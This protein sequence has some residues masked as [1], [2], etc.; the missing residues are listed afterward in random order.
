VEKNKDTEKLSAKESL[1]IAIWSVKI[2]FQIDKTRSILYIVF[3]IL[4]NLQSIVN[5]ILVAK[6][7]DQLIHLLQTSEAELIDMVPIL[8][9]L[10]AYNVLAGVLGFFNNYTRSVL[11]ISVD[12][13][14]EQIFYKKLQA[15][16]IKT[17]EDPEINNK[18]TRA[19]GQISGVEFYFRQLISVASSMVSI[20]VNGAIILKFSPILIPI[21]V[22]TSIP[23]R[24]VDKKYRSLVWKLI[25]DTTEKQRAANSTAGNLKSPIT[26]PEIIINKATGYLD[27]KYTEYQNWYAGKNRALYKKWFIGIYSWELLSD[28]GMFSGYLIIFSNALKKLITIGDVYFQTQILQKLSSEINSAITLTNN[29]FDYSIR[30]KEVY[31]LFNLPDENVSGAIKLAKLDKGPEIEF[32]DLTFQYP[33]TIKKVINK[34]NL[35]IKSGEKIAIVGANGAGKTTLMKILC[36]VYEPTGGVILVNG[37]PLRDIENSTWYDNVGVLFQEYNTHGQLTVKENI[38]IGN[39]N[40]KFDSKKMLEAAQNADAL[41]FIQEYP[42]KFDQVLSQQYKN[43]IRPSTGQWQKIAIARFFYRNAPLVIFDEPTASIDSVSEYHIF[44]KIYRFFKRK[45]VIIISHRFSTVRNADRIVVIDKGTIVEEG[46]H[47]ELMKL[48]GKYNK[49]FSLQAE[50]YK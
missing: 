47:E 7:F 31:T 10:L 14:I 13:K 49:S 40:V 17:L 3:S 24:L 27:K 23:S 16:G 28:V 48:K 32:K 12:Q 45:T 46:T 29:L 50:G 8:G 33:N 34:L 22:I 20:V 36:N 15:L 38:V 4:N 21:V 6:A 39:P 25:R 18:I 9:M 5:T 26:L 42:N 44:N 41:E 43:G 2:L 1:S 37:Y 35:K 11:S 19:R 30:M